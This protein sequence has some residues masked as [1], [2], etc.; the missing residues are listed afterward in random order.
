MRKHDDGTTCRCA[1]F[2]GGSRDSGGPPP[3]VSRDAPAPDADLGSALR[4]V[5]HGL[6]KAIPHIPL[7]AQPYAEEMVRR[8]RAALEQAGDVR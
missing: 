6:E 2:H 1:G 3:Q 8:G 7:E 4:L 5:V